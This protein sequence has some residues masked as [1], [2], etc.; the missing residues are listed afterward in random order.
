VTGP[1]DTPP[2]V[3]SDTRLLAGI[4]AVAVTAAA[5]VVVAG[6]ISAAV[7]GG[8]CVWPPSAQWGSIVRGVL[9]HAHDPAAGWPAP[10]ARRIPGPRPYWGTY[11]V[12]CLVAAGT[13]VTVWG[14]VAGRS[15]GAGRDGLARPAQLRREASATAARRRRGVTRPDLIGR[16]RHRPCEFGYPLGRSTH[17]GIAL[18]APWEA[19]LRVIG[20]PGEGK[21]FRVLARILRQHPGP[22]VATSTKADLYELTADA[23][24][25]HGPVAVFDPDRLVPTAAGVQ[26]SPVA[27]CEDSVL[28]ERRAAA[29]LAAAGDSGDSRYGTFFADAARDVLKAYLHAAALSGGDIRTVLGWS[30]RLDDPE[31]GEILRTDPDA[32][33]GWAGIITVHT[34]GAAE[35]TSGV[36]RHLARALACFSHPHVIASCCPGPG[37]AFDAARF[38]EANGTVY[39]L[40]KD[41]G[42]GAVAPLLTAFAQEVFDAAERLANRRRT[43]RLSPPLLGLLDEAPSIAPIPTLPALLAD[44]RGR[45]IVMVY[46]MQSFSQAVTRWGATQAETMA[47]ATNIT[48]I[49]GGLTS[50]RDLSDLERVCGTRQV[51]RETVHR[52]GER[53]TRSATQTWE[54]QPVLRAADIRTL[55]AG[56]TLVLWGRLAPILA[57]QPLLSEDRDWRQTQAA[58]AGYL[59][60]GDGP[61]EVRPR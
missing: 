6:A 8:G 13:G 30:R 2:G 19:S 33:P 49:F 12:V 14:R 45:G 10:F 50:A 38:L 41:T 40:G 24:A 55:P 57:R 42:L 52:G 7:F 54:T 23:R 5:L 28:A 43:H 37:E 21:T 53:N 27:G 3:N 51:C 18:W 29:L 11:A 35:T 16:A 34:T 59:T 39:L 31:P 4:A 20:P 48:M 47:N 61:E 60:V 25:E 22:A 15:S 17:A 56:V 44:G 26:W 36:M 32:V 9:T 1:L 58:R 46:A